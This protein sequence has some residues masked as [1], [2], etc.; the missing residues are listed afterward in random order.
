MRQIAEAHSFGTEERDGRLCVLVPWSQR[1]HDGTLAT[2]V[3]R[4]LVGGAR[5]LARVLGY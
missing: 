5:D 1:L 4:E 3:D 2:G